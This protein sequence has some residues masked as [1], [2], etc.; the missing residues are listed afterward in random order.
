MD[1]KDV[2]RDLRRPFTPE[3]VKFKVQ[4]VLGA[5]KG[6][7]IVAYID[8]RL[9]IER[10]NAVVPGEWE[11][12]YS[13]VDGKANLLWCHLQLGPF[14]AAD[15]MPRFVT[16]R[17]V[18]ESP[19][20][21]SKDLVSDALKR[22]AVHFGVGVSVYALPQITLWASDSKG[23]L[24]LRG[25][26]NKQSL[27]LTPEGHRKLREGYRTWLEANKSFGD[28]LDHGDTEGATLDPEE[29][30]EPAAPAAPELKD[31]G[32]LGGKS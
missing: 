6:A 8:A 16:R 25:S 27:V 18:G 17:D 1:L 22:A 13:A 30:E 7:L 32:Y 3:A 29:H 9:V 20:G 4:T 12:A 23:A 2:T 19:K 31:R 5:N 21:M 15:G 26:A 28:P 24:E 14:I 11:A 10:L